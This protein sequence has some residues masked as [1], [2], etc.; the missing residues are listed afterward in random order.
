MPIN[1]EPV[2][3]VPDVTVYFWITTLLASTMGQA[4]ADAVNANS[5]LG[6]ANA[7]WLMTGVVIIALTAQ[8]ALNR[9]VPT[10][11]WLAVVLA[12]TVG[13]LLADNLPGSL[14]IPPTMFTATCAVALSAVFAAWYAVERSVS[15]DSIV[16][17]RRETFYWVAVVLMFA[18]GAATSNVVAEQLGLGYLASALIAGAIICAVAA[19]DYGLDLHMVSA[20]WGAYAL[21]GVVGVSGCDLLSQ[22]STAGGLGLGAIATSMLMGIGVVG[23]VWFL[24]ASKVDQMLPAT[25]A[26]CSPTPTGLGGAPAA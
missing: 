1:G 4:V 8:F 9:Y 21:I 25:G 19:L 5:T 15:I 26:E 18:F 23:L 2:R 11:Y 17:V 13:T 20:F 7:T 10:V 6:P 24:T 14:G 12:C 22:D 3:K 16:T